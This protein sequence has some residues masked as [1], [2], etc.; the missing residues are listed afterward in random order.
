[1]AKWGHGRHVG[2]GGVDG[3]HAADDASWIVLR[4]L[5]VNEEVE[6]MVTAFRLGIGCLTV[7]AAYH[8]SESDRLEARPPDEYHLDRSIDAPPSGAVQKY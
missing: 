2:F 3:I 6:E 5:L 4:D 1:M 8:E 7:V